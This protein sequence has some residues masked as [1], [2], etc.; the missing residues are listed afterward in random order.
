MNRPV[1]FLDIDGVL[2]SNEH[3]ELMV[4]YHREGFT[5]QDFINGDSPLCEH[6]LVM[7][8]DREHPCFST[9]IGIK[10]LANLTRI[11]EET[12]AIIIGVS[13]W[14]H[15]AGNKNNIRIEKFL[16]LYHDQAHTQSIAP[17]GF[18]YEYAKKVIEGHYEPH[19]KWII[20]DDDARVG[21]TTENFK[22]DELYEISGDTGLTEADVPVII[23]RLVS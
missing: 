1:I 12:N 13:A 6:L 2:N 15:E 10:Q 11:V 7:N 9:Q 14:Y 8:E 3:R 4:K 20:L 18:R 21:Y 23:S 22:K 17:V 19:T 5:I 16:G